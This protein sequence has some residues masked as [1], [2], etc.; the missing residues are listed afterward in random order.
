[1]YKWGCDG[2]NLKQYKQKFEED[3]NSDA[4]IFL[5]SLVP[6]RLM[7]GNQI[8]WQNPQSSSPRFC[9]PIRI[10]FIKEDKDVTNEEIQ[11]IDNQAQNLEV[12]VVNENVKVR[13]VLFPT[14]VDGKVCNAAT[15]TISTLRCYVCGKTS[16][17]FNDLTSTKPERTETFKF[18]LSILHARIRFFEFLLHLSYKLSAKVHKNRINDKNDKERIQMAKV[19]IQKEFKDKLG[20]LVDIPKVG[21]GNTNDGNTSRR[22]FENEDVA[23]SITGIN[24]E[25]IKKFK[26]IL[27]VLSSGFEIDL[28]K[29]SSFTMSTAKMYVNLLYS[30]QPMSPTVHK[31]LV[32]SSGVI[33]HALLPIGQLSEEAAEERNKHFRQYRESYS[34][35]FSRRECNEDV[36][37]RLLL[38]SDPYLSC[39][40][41]KK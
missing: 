35:K 12:T 16:K 3:G 23:A 33:A 20:L 28:E 21:Y 19:N 27:E 18:G 26:I 5:S 9:R 10:R 22:F 37:N 17:D 11:F 36:L 6:L 32:H 39:M 40:R 7:Y 41:S 8:I 1:M 34:R 29:F 15:A 25:L 2:S 38:T 14:M 24:I 13:H 30:W 31:I 4:K